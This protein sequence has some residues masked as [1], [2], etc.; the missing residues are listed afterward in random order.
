MNTA[1]DR[2]FLPKPTTD[3]P[4]LRRVT[5]AVQK[6]GG[7][8]LGQGTC[9]LPVPELVLAAA[10]RAL[11]AGY[12]RY[13]LPCGLLET[14]EAIAAKL[15]TFNQF[16]VDPNTEVAIT[17]GVT[18]AFEAVCRA[19][20]E[21]GD[22]VVAFEPYYP[23]LVRT[24]VRVRYVTLEQPGWRFNPESL[25]KAITSRTK[26]ILVNTPSNPTG[27]VFSRTELEMIGRLCDEHNLLLVTDEMYEYMTFDGHRHLSA[28]AI[29]ELKDR[30]ITMGGYSKTFA[31]TGWRVGYIAASSALITLFSRVI[32]ETYICTPAPFQHALATVLR[33][34]PS[35]FYD[36]LGAKYA[37]KRDFFASILSEIGFD[38][39]IPQG[40]YYL[41]AD[42]QR[43]FGSMPSYDF[44][45]KMIDEAKIGAVP[46]NDFV[47]APAKANWVRFCV[48]VEDD[49]LTQAAEQLRGLRR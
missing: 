21:P 43:A 2:S 36:E 22:E 27:K 18:G 31:V 17:P 14:R 48:A 49:V 1:A 12:N 11:R 7:I 40:A 47:T 10:E 41:V 42:F 39:C 28:A 13:T 5:V 44:V 8:N 3:V 29:P 32:D 25:R 24:G 9:Q 37:R 16:V 35:E 46:S 20:L 6:V 45:L 38:V 4:F 33:E 15:S 26:F 30:T 34:L 19:L 23:Y